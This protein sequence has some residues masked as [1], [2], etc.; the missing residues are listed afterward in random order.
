[1]IYPSVHVGFLLWVLAFLFVS[2]YFF[3]AKDP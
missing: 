1:M 2:A 3:F